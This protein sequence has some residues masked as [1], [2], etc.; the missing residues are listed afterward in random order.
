MDDDDVL[1]LILSD[2]VNQQSQKA[3]QKWVM[4]H[5]PVALVRSDLE[6]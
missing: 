6:G 4:S 5:G 1:L 3:D 2:R